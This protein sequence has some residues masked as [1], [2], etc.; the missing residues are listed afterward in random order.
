MEIPER[1]GVVREEES[2]LPEPLV[3]EAETGGVETGVGG[4]D[5]EDNVL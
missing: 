2:N 3:L 1:S 5:C 4:G